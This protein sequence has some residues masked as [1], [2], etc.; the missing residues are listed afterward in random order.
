MTEDEMLNGITNSM[1]MSVRWGRT[2]KPG[3]L[4]S[5]GLQR[6]R[7]DLATGQQCKIKSKKKKLCLVPPN[8]R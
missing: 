7:Y 2:W 4:K 6:V 5:K 1:N 8:K 3:M